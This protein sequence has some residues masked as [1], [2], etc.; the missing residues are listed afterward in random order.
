MQTELKQRKVTIDGK[1]VSIYFRTEREYQQKYREK[2]A[3][4]E[5]GAY[6]LQHMTFAAVADEWQT[7]HDSTIQHYTRQCYVAP[8]KD[9]L[10]WFGPLEISEIRPRELQ[11]RLD[12]MGRA[13]FAFQTIKLRKNVLNMVYNYALL[14]GYVT[15][16]PVP[17]LTVPRG[18]PR[19]QRE[20]PPEDSLRVIFDNA[21]KPLGM[22]YLLAACTGARRGEIMALTKSDL[23]FTTNTITFNKVLILS[24]NTTPQIRPGTKSKAGNRTVPILPALRPI[25]QDYISS[26]PGDYLFQINGA[27]YLKWAFDKQS[28][29]YRA[30]TGLDLTG[31]QLR[32]LYATLC[33]DA[34][35]GVKDTQQLLGHS[36]AG[37]TM[38]IYTHIRDSRRQAADAALSAALDAALSAEAKK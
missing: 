7:T 25:L 23:D 34:G 19:T 6:R 29:K 28:A 31:H 30:A 21:D 36:K 27:P 18:A 15:S 32:H 37:T 1:R 22:Y 38:D 24:N 3:A 26:L 16:N 9:L 2:L 33:Y 17:A 14:N 12:H 10:A 4:A 11:D 20:L 35:L 5:R 13:G 8:L